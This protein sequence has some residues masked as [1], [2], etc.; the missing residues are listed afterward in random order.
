MRKTTLILSLAL[1]GTAAPA[2]VAPA[3]AQEQCLAEVERLADQFGLESEAP[4][5]PSQNTDQPSG[6]SNGA[7]TGS[8][9]SSQELAESGGVIR[10]PPTGSGIVVNPPAQSADPMPTAP[11]VEPRS[12]GQDTTGLNAAKRAQLETLLMGARSAAEQGDGERCQERLQEARNIAR[13]GAN[14]NPM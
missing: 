9:T 12:G 7:D 10:P 8:G 13:N 6:R 3:L 1:A 4:Q 5:A 11:E 2:F 14:E